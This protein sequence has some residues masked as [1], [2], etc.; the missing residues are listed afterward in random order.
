MEKVTRM[1]TKWVG[2]LSEILV[3]VRH[4]MRPAASGGSAECIEKLVFRRN[5]QD[6]AEVYTGANVAENPLFTIAV[7]ALDAGDAVSVCW[8]DSLGDEGNASL[9]VG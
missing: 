1:R 9:V 3:L 5:G 2:R 8:R 4:P 6:V 7:D